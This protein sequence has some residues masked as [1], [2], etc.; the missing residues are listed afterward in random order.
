VISAIGT[1]PYYRQ[2]GFTDGELYQHLALDVPSAR[3]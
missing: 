2:I 1:R 3:G